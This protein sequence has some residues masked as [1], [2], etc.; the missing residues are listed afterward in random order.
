MDV[1]AAIQYKKV[2][3]IGV[4]Q[5]MNSEVF[6]AFDPQL[7]GEIAVKEIPKGHFGNNFG[8]YHRE[9]RVLFATEHRNVVP[10]RYGCE[11]A[12]HVCL[13][14]P[15]FKN[16][17]LAS[18][19]ATGPLRLREVKRV[20]LEV[21]NALMRV[22]IK[23]FLHFDVKPSN[24]LFSDIDVAMLSDFGQARRVL[25]G[26]VVQ[27][28]PLYATAV[29]PEC[30]STGVGTVESDVYQ[31]G[32][33]LYRMANGDPF[34]SGQQ[35]KTDA[36]LRQK[37]ERGKFPKRDAFLPH[38]PRRLRTIIKKALRVSPAERYRAAADFAD[39]LG[40]VR[41]PLDWEAKPVVGGGFTWTARRDAQPSLVV[42]LK[43]ESSAW[44]VEVNTVRSGDLP[45]AKNRSDFW[46]RGLTY[47]GALEF[48]RG[49]FKSLRR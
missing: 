31:M 35:P 18:R 23:D 44:C 34:F 49:V 20:G 12:T 19:I 2:Q 17:S 4:G 7:N 42:E 38:V 43:P 45:R 41:L 28:P 26:G 46:R 16:G 36:E 11:T 33:L 39:A 29:P 6:L 37:V 1:L 47:P 48:L 14:M 5:G 24:V 8:E 40:R 13:A 32:L 21:L 9:A 10:V 27:V 15:Y 22:H 30:Y 25:P 3:P